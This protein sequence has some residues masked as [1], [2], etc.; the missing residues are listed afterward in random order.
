[1]FKILFPIILIF[2]I[3]GIFLEIIG[4]E[5]NSGSVGVTD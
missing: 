1:M 5:L 4:E 2:W 3:F